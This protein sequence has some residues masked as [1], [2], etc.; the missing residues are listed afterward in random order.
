MFLSKAELF[1]ESSWALW[2][3]HAAGLLPIAAL[4]L[5]EGGQEGAVSVWI[6]AP[7]L[8]E[9]NQRMT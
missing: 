5:Q 9:C 6:S 7:Y 3:Q 1:H 2:F 4:K 8:L